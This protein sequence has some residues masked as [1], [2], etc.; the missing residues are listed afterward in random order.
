MLQSQIQLKPLISGNWRKHKAMTAYCAEWLSTLLVERATWMAHA[1]TIELADTVI[2]G[3]GFSWFRFWMPAL[4][5]VAE[6]YFDGA[7]KEIGVYFPVCQ[8]LVQEGKR[9]HTSELILAVWY[10][11]AKRVSVLR[12]AEFDEAVRRQMISDNEAARAETR[13]RK[14]TAAIFR[15]EFPPPVVRHF[16]VITEKRV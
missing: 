5:Q 7:G 11:V 1:P 16:A 6:K 15:E 12:E 9:Y 14:L 13:I 2:S 10:D 3:P 8:P 4:D